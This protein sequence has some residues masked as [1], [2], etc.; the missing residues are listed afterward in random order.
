MKLQFSKYQ[1]AGNDFIL[2]DNLSGSF[3]NLT[4]FDIQF[5]CDRKFG[6]GAD[7]LIKINA[8]SEYDFEVD[9]FNADASKSF[10]GNGGRCA[11]AFA[12][13]LNIPQET[14]VFVGYDGLHNYSIDANEIVCIS[15]NEVSEII[16]HGDDF[17]VYTGSPHYVKFVSN[18]AKYP[19]FEE[20]KKIRTSSPFDQ[21]GINVNFV[22]LTAKDFMYV[23][24]YERGVE[25]E[26][27]ACGT[28]V[29]AC[30]LVHAYKG[31]VLGAK[32]ITIIAKGGELRVDFDQIEQA[33]FKNIFLSG[34]AAFVFS[35]QINI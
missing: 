26:T 3:D 1:G 10:C 25:D 15:M 12:K 20:G 23:R 34:P 30:A 4:S 16:H 29:T 2:L 21:A 14:N 33:V 35:G 27:L 8:H 9:Y 24:T 28:G 5:L 6:I 19:V 11:V 7:G 18:L 22:E 31:D 17:E 32:S 13:S